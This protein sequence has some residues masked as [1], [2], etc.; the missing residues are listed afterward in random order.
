MIMTLKWIVHFR[1]YM[2]FKPY[3]NWSMFILHDSEFHKNILI[4]VYKVCQEYFLPVLLGLPIISF[5]FPLAPFILL[6]R[7][8]I[9]F[10]ANDDV[11]CG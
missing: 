11:L 7:C 10:L 2:D 8:H 6:D 5:P 1:I 4:Q 3:F 9:H